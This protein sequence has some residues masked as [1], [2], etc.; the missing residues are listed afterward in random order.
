VHDLSALTGTGLTHRWVA[1]GVQEPGAPPSGSAG[2]TPS[3]PAPASAPSPEP[4]GAA[5]K[6]RRNRKARPHPYAHEASTPEETALS[7]RRVAVFWLALAAWLIGSGYALASRYSPHV[8]G[9]S[10]PLASWDSWLQIPLFTSI[11]LLAFGAVDRPWARRLSMS[12]WLVG[13]FYL[14]LWA[15]DLYFVAN[16]D[17]VNWAFALLFG[18]LF[19][20]LAYHEW[21][22]LLRGVSN[23]A[24]KFLAV[25]FFVGAGAYFL[26]DKV[27]TLRLGLI[28]VVSDHTKWMLDLFGQGDRAGIVF[29]VD[30]FDNKS[31][32]TFY[33]PDTVDSCPNG[34][35]ESEFV[36]QG[37]GTPSQFGAW[38]TEQM[39]T[40]ATSFWDK[41]LHFD[42]PPGDHLILRVSIILACT[43]LQSIMVFVGLFAGTTATWRRKLYASLIV[44]VIV[45][46]LNLVRNTGIIWFYGQGHASFWIMHDA[47]GKGGSLLA[48]ILIAFGVFRWF[49]EFL[50][51][52]FGVLDLVDRDGPLERGLKLGRRRP[53]LAQP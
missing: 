11:A 24:V 35:S 9:A 15:Q 19:V 30:R 39:S 42:P 48:M 4:L 53:A 27:Q 14:G 32:T 36:A 37:L 25:S 51:A 43:A 50:K 45:Y 28:H 20:Y 22:S 34:V 6:G 33:Y 10:E 16:Q 40:F 49:P 1:R 44:G 46:I 18:V 29:E 21:L 7:P 5:S 2:P 26:I 3:S 13:A 17:Y 12:A 52:L 41:I 47:I 23:P 8:P 38:C 31:P